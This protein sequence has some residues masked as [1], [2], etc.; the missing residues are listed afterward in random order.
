MAVQD[1]LFAFAGPVSEQWING[2]N[3]FMLHGMKINPLFAKLDERQ[4]K[5]FQDA[6]GNAMHGI[7][8]IGA[9]VQ[10]GADIESL[11]ERVSAVMKVDDSAAF[12][13]R[14]RESIDKM[15]EVL[16]E[17]RDGSSR[18]YEIEEIQVDG[19]PALLIR[20]D[21]KSMLAG[22]PAAANPTTEKLFGPEGK[23]DA[24]LT[25]ADERTVIAAYSSQA[26]LKKAVDRYR[27]A[28]RGSLDGPSSE[29]AALLP[30]QSQWI[31]FASP[32]GGVRWFRSMLGILP[33][34]RQIKIPDF[35]ATPP[36]GFAIKLS[37]IGVDT[38][39]VIP[40]TVI[41]ATGEFVQK[42]R[43]Q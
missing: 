18:L 3:T 6:L 37:A 16:T 29:T 35:P 8:A 32:A 26:A 7:E 27:S 25:A 17:A 4:L 15:D 12:L 24:Y 39:F 1:S 34:G 19:K 14:Y 30:K 9:V 36:V 40:S 11:Y 38:D 22:S 10:A 5:R 31:G 23:L 33:A 28:N 43:K 21:M 20:M 2:S 41:R 42:V 13:K